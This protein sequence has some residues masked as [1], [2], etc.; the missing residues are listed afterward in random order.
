MVSIFCEKT[1]KSRLA[2]KLQNSLFDVRKLSKS[3]LMSS[4]ILGKLPPPHKSRLALKLH[5]TFP[6]VR[7]LSKSRLWRQLFCQKK[8]HESKLALKLQKTSPAVRKLSKSRLIASKFLR[9]KPIQI[10]P[11]VKITEHLTH[12]ETFE[13]KA[14]GV[15][16]FG[17]TPHKSRLWRKIF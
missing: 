15:D 14:Y 6:A 9:K 10:K 3:K 17:K 11:C 1:H 4:I 5:S 2:L 16:F 7:K 13:I 8:N 12:W